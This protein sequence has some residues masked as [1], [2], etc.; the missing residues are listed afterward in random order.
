[1]VAINTG[2]MNIKERIQDIARLC[3]KV[4]EGIKKRNRGVPN[5]INYCPGEQK[6]IHA[7]ETTLPLIE[8]KEPEIVARLKKELDVLVG[9]PNSCVNPYAFGA[10]VGLWA[11]L[12]AQYSRVGSGKKIFISHSSK[13]K[14]YVIDFVNHIL[15]LGIGVD[16]DDIF[17]TSIEDLGIRN[18]ED[19]RL[20]IQDTIRSAE[21]SFILLSENYKDSEICINEMGAV[22]AYDANVRIY[23]LPNTDFPAIGWLCDTRKADSVSNSVALDSLYKEMIEHFGLPDRLIH[24]SQQRTIFLDRLK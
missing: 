7:I 19:I 11:V 3:D 20:H 1:M 15:C 14:R 21:Y 4:A 8:K 6:L 10:I 16:R 22:W 9:P 2:E 13:D 23:L 5:C 24:W 17:C 12:N 18:G